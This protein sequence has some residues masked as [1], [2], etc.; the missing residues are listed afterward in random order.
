MSL[1]VEDIGRETFLL[2]MMRLDYS[3]IKLMYKTA[4]QK[5][6]TFL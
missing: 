4:G 6:G 2:L 5:R 3:A 1:S